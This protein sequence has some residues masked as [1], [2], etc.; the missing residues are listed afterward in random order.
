MLP[1]NGRDDSPIFRT[2]A[3]RRLDFPTFVL[4]TISTSSPWSIA[5]PSEKEAISVYKASRILL[6]RPGHSPG[7]RSSPSSARIYR[8]LNFGCKAS[9][10]PNAA[11]SRGQL[12]LAIARALFSSSAPSL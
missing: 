8:G 3:L 11:Y 2:R 6:T 9:I 12:S 1:G 5:R 10:S 7:L 4:P